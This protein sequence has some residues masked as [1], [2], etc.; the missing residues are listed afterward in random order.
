MI[1][2]V[3][4]RTF[5][6]LPVFPTGLQRQMFFLLPWDV[7]YG[8]QRLPS[9]DAICSASTRIPQEQAIRPGSALRLR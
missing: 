7:L 8:D 1:V 3:Q 6:A 4:H 9:L 2:R 5:R